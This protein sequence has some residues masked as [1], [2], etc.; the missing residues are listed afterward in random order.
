MARGGKQE[1]D[2]KGERREEKEKKKEKEKETN[3]NEKENEIRKRR[4]RKDSIK[5]LREN[6]GKYLI[7]M[8]AKVKYK[9]K[10]KKRIHKV[11]DLMA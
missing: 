3:R 8:Y 5:Q 1:R 10:H 11:T 6:T 2:G 9:N 7:S 4:K